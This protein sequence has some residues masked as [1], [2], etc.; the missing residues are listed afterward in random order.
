MGAAAATWWAFLCRA[1]G[2]LLVLRLVFRLVCVDRIV[3]VVVPCDVAEIR[4]VRIVVLLVCDVMLLC[5]VV[6]GAE[7]LS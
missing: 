3:V 1:V 5:V 7:A 2:L 4:V 6:L